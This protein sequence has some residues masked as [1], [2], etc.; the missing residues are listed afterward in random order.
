M[1]VDHSKIY[2]ANPYYWNMAWEAFLGPPQKQ[3][4]LLILYQPKR[5]YPRQ[6]P[7]KLVPDRAD[8]TALNSQRTHSTRMGHLQW[9]EQE[10]LKVP[11]NNYFD[12]R[13]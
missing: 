12:K 3:H 9:T 10:I 1:N 5:D 13:L 6:Q 7:E 2:E 4:E 11:G 8:N